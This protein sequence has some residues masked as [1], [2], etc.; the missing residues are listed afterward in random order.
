[1]CWKLMIFSCVFLRKHIETY[2]FSGIWK[3]FLPEIVCRSWRTFSG[4][5]IWVSHSLLGLVRDNNFK[6]L[7]LLFGLSSMQCLALALIKVSRWTS[8]NVTIGGT[9][10]YCLFVH[11]WWLSYWTWNVGIIIGRTLDYSVKV[12]Q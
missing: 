3:W 6:F 2:C 9:N 10:D 7:F 4:V 5:N 1:M 11:H 12:D 8:I